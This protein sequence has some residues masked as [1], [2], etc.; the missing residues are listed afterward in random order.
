MKFRQG[1]QILALDLLSIGI[2]KQQMH[3]IS[4]IGL[5]LGVMM[6]IVF[7]NNNKMDTFRIPAEPN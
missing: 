3:G 5:L 4:L 2:G 7:N 6:H 1:K